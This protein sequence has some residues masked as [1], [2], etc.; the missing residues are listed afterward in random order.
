MGSSYGKAKTA[1]NMEFGVS[2]NTIEVLYFLPAELISLP[3]KP[4]QSPF[5]PQIPH[6]LQP[7]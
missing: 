6:S 2:G 7:L 1:V 4:L 5:T 3:S